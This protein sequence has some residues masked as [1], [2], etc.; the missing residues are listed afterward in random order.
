MKDPA[1]TPRSSTT[2]GSPRA[3]RQVPRGSSRSTAGTS[4]AQPRG[5]GHARRAGRRSWA[6]YCR[7]PAPR[8]MREGEPDPPPVEG[9]RR[10]SPRHRVR[11]PAGVSRAAPA[12]AAD[13]QHGIAEEDPAPAELFGDRAGGQRPDD[14]GHHPAGGERGHHRGP[15][16]LRIGPADDDVQRDDHQPA[17]ESLHGAP[18]DEHPHGLGASPR[19]PAPPRRPPI[20][21]ASGR[22][23]A[24]AG[25]TTARR[26]PSRTG[27]S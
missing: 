8:E 10:P 15:Q 12:R 11:S 20:P 22:E 17:A 13:D 21:A 5:G 7:S 9:A 25:R 27:S 16:P 1:A 14:R 19:A 18:E 23:R 2:E 4:S 24:A 3:A 26:P 6:A